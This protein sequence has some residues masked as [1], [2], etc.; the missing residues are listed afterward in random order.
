VE[1]YADLSEAARVMGIEGSDQIGDCDSENPRVGSSVL[2]LATIKT[3]G[4]LIP[5]R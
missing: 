3:R 5:L 1:I 4:Y 2:S